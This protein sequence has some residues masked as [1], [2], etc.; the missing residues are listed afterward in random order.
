V[1][2]LER[3]DHGDQNTLVR[4]EHPKEQ[5]RKN[6]VRPA[7]LPL[8]EDVSIQCAKDR[9]DEGR[10]HCH[11]KTIAEIPAQ[12]LNACTAGPGVNVALDAQ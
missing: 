9:R 3:K 4:N 7:E 10:R 12:S 1:Q 2:A 8:G 5:Q 6:D 11:E